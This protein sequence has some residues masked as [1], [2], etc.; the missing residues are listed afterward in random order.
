MNDNTENP[1][2]DSMIEMFGEGGVKFL[3]TRSEYIEKVLLPNIQ[4]HWDEPDALA[5]TIM[6]AFNDAWYAQVE[7]AAKRLVEID[8]IS[9]RSICLYGTVLL[10]TEQYLEAEAL[11]LDYLKD[12]PRHPYVLTNLAKAQDFLDKTAEA[13]ITLE[14]SI[15]ADPNQEN[16]TGWWQIIKKEAFESEGLTD[17]QATLSSLKDINERF[18]GWLVKLWLGTHFISKND[19]ETARSYY[20]AVLGDAWEPHVLT[21]I[22]SELGKNGFLH[23]AIELVVPHYNP[24]QHPIETGLN[25][26]QAYL[27]LEQPSEGQQLLHELYSID[28]PDFSEHLDGYKVEFLKLTHPMESV[29]EENLNVK[30]ESIDYPLWC[31]GWNI[32]H[33]FDVSQSGKK[34]AIFQFSC[35]SEEVSTEVSRHLE[36]TEGRL[37]RAIPLFLLEAIYYGT[38]ASSS[39]ILP[40]SENEG[41]YI[42]YSNP[43]PS[44]QIKAL[45]EQGYDGVV[46]GVIA[47]NELNMTYLD[48][49]TG[50]EAHQAFPFDSNGPENTLS[51]IEAFVFEKSAI[52][53]DSNFKKNKRGFQAIPHQHR[54]DY[55]ML[56]SQHL[57]LYKAIKF[58]ETVD[59]HNLVRGFLKLAKH[60]ETTQIQ[61]NLISVIHL[62]MRYK[63]QAIQDYKGRISRW[64]DGIAES[65]SVLHG[66][67]KKTS[68]VFKAYCAV[69][70]DT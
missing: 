46:T 25:V 58:S 44:K 47:S 49:V 30:L 28:R 34:I 13:L 22:S 20:E 53:F 51:E 21:S 54:N 68:D 23:E 57:T 35:Q 37:A 56:S 27:E 16:A 29:S 26:L 7:E 17:E 40:V 41:A 43:P 52:D 4:L 33:G 31:Y 9:E 1:S 66:I 18:G 32:K 63:S 42:L 65:E 24:H 55:L 50:T 38:D 45:S 67:A 64:L 36:N 8:P 2:Q 3:I 19:I 15:T 5:S 6:N 69:D 14:E 70:S 59:E 48:L 39:V 12:N 11:F 60:A 10:K 61:L 62:C